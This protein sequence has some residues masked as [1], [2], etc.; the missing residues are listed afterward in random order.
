MAFI[1]TRKLSER[2]PKPGWHGRFFDSDGMS[3]AYYNLEAGAALDE[4]SHPNEE[5]WNVVAGE[6]E[7]TIGEDRHR[8]GPGAAALVPPN[9]AHSVRAIAASTVIV[10]D[11][12][13]R[14]AVGGSGRA[15]LAI[16]FSKFL[17]PSFAPIGEPIAI[18]FVIRNHGRSDGIVKRIE[19]DSAVAT[20]LPPP[21]R[22]LIPAGELSLQIA[23]AGGGSHAATHTHPPLTG[24]QR[25]Q[26]REGKAVFYVRGV[27]L[28][29]DAEG[30]RHH[31]TF[32]RVLDAAEGLIAPERPG[33]NYGD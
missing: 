11:A 31:T 3:F 16:Q 12:P 32:C 2:E 14:G 7:I 4:H 22:T 30:E 6:V 5:V 24:A 21:T 19:I 33:Y 1:D 9:T 8:A 28:Y 26:L 27:L 25:E 10:V 23:I 20:S 15:A 17:D 29:E 13:R 18:S